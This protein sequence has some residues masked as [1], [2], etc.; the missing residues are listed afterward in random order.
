M[1]VHLYKPN[2]FIWPIFELKARSK[3]W[4]HPGWNAALLAISFFD[5]TR[6]N[7]SAV[8]ILMLR[9]NPTN[10]RNNC[11]QKIFVYIGAFWQAMK[12]AERNST[13]DRPTAQY[14]IC[15]WNTLLHNKCV[16]FAFSPIICTCTNYYHAVLT[17]WSKRSISVVSY[18][19]RVTEQ[20]N[21]TSSFKSGKNNVVRNLCSYAPIE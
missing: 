12:Q 6:D 3:Q 2:C 16:F 4:T 7:A 1:Q 14:W 9:L 5:S 8:G 19:V 17:I 13:I 21:P 15:P 20:F 11:Y 10:T 18:V